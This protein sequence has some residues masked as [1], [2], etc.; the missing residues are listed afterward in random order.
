M[1]CYNVQGTVDEAILS[2]MGQSLIDFEIVAVDDGSS[3]DTL[4]RL[5]D[6]ALR[7]QRIHI[8]A[9]QHQGIVAALNAGL[10]G[11]KA[12]YIARMDA[13]DRC[14][15]ERLFKQVNMLEDHPE[16]AIIGSLVKGFPE[17]EIGLEFRIYIDWLNSSLSDIE[18]KRG[19]FV[20]SPLAHPSTSY[21]HEW[22]DRVG[23]YQDHGW[24]E[25]YDLWMRMFLSGAQFGKVPEVLLEWRDHPRR[26]THTDKHYSINSDLNLK[27][28]Y[29]ML[30]PLRGRDGVFMW[31]SGQTGKR[32]SELLLH[33][34]CPVS[35]TVDSYWAENE[36]KMASLP[37][38]VPEGLT[39]MVERCQHP[40]VLVTER[41]NNIKES[42]SQKL[43]ALGMHELQ[44]WW[45]VA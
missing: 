39:D 34:G 12:E 3:D 14:T 20:Q 11:C 33:L 9:L 27:A 44:D 32:L 43:A 41:M 26:L 1:P 31:G 17:G 15:P 35:A 16:L 40:A 36:S 13:D 7:D 42:I 24:A 2:L 5:H 28:H 18:I 4:R 10:E 8:L 6:W 19:I 29:L 38:C 25:D 37:S 22:I 45:A 23:G 21:R 30:G